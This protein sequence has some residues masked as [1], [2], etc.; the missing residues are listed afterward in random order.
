MRE[1]TA[2]VELSY[3]T[4]SIVESLSEQVIT[5]PAGKFA[6]LRRMRSAHDVRHDHL[7]ADLLLKTGAPA[8]IWCAPVFFEQWRF[9]AHAAAV[10]AGTAR[11]RAH[12]SGSAFGSALFRAGYS[13]SRLL[14]LTAARGDALFDQVRIAV[15]MVARAGQLPLDL[16]TIKYLL[17]DCGVNSEAARLLIARRYYDAGRR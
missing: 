16:A 1:V 7:I 3:S 2:A 12:R 14:R 6:A 15:Y 10:L 4:D 5:L 13:E 17:E 9:I 8:N 11:R